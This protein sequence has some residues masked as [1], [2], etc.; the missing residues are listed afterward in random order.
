[1]KMGKPNNMFAIVFDA[2]Y[3]KATQ[4]DDCVHNRSHVWICGDKYQCVKHWDAHY[5]SSV[6]LSMYK[7][8]IHGLLIKVKKAIPVTGHEG[9]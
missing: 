7:I 5:L 8:W 6:P 9:P 1:M 4:C 3:V 2:H